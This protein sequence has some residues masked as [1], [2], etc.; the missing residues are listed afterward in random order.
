MDDSTGTLKTT[1]SGLDLDRIRSAIGPVL[2]AHRVAL[3][4]LEWLTDRGHW[5]LRL[6]IEHEGSADALGGVTLEEC[7]EVSHDVSAVLDVD[8]MIPHQYYLEVSSP[9][10]DRVLRTPADFLRFVGR[11]A[12]VKLAKPAPD[13]QRVLRGVL[14]EAR[15]D[16]VALIADGKP[17]EVLF[18]NI[19][20]ARLVF[21]LEKR[22]KQDRSRAPHD[23]RSRKAPQGN[24]KDK[25]HGR[26][27]GEAKR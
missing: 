22:P 7:A 18:A 25:G 9:G 4:D 16:R 3:V 19:A 17:F 6:T 10:L 24:Q 8:D 11:K 12:K 21:E 23:K 14:A 26:L 2:S 20:E 13:G 27:S 1:G 5:T 15:E